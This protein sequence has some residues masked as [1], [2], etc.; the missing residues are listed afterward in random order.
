V[1]WGEPSW[2]VGD[3]IGLYFGGTLKVPVLVEVIAPPEFNLAMVQEDAHGEE[4]DAG[5]RWPWVTRVRGMRSVSLDRAPTLDDLGISHELV[6]RRPRFT[7]TPDQ[8]DR[9]VQALA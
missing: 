3:E 5:E 1:P 9:L 4:P 2:K 7:I 8:H 6:Q